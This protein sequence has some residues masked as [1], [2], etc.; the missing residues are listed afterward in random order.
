MF[1]TKWSNLRGK[2]LNASLK[3]AEYVGC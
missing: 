3:D 2:C 1:S